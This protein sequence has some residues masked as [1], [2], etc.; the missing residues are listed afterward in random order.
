MMRGGAMCVRVK[1]TTGQKPLSGCTIGVRL[2]DNLFGLGAQQ[3][4]GYS[5]SLH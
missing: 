5:L 2:G 3:I 4:G 1:C